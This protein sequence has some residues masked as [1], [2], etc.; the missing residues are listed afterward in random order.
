MTIKT[1]KSII[2]LGSP[3]TDPDK[4]IREQRFVEASKAAAHFINNGF[5]EVFSPIAHFHPIAKHG[6]LPGSWDFWKKID[7]IYL[8]ISK[9]FWI[10]TLDGWKESEGL[11]GEAEISRNFCI[12]IR[13]VDPKDYSISDHAFIED[14]GPPR[15][16]R[17]SKSSKKEI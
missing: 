8:G 1:T 9:E 6:G 11:A 10:L 14:Q 13:L 5:L 12:P 3:Y 2:Y 7:E 17:F 15:R 16:D 4:S